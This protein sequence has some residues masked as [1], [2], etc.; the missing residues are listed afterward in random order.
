MIDLSTA[1][2][3]FSPVDLGALAYF[4]AAWVGYGLSVGRLRGRMVSLTQIMNRHRANWARQ[5]IGRDNRVVDTQI[6]ASLQNG[7][8]FFASTS[9]IALGSVLTLSRSGDDV[10]NMFA[11][12]PFGTVANR[13]TWELKVAGLA[14]VFV[15][16]F[17]KFAWA[18]RL[19]NYAAILLGAVP[20]RGTASEAEM[21]RAVRRV[22]VM[23]VAAGG[24]FARGQRAFFFALAYLGWFV[25]PYILFVSTTG[26]VAVMW[27]RQFASGIRTALLGLG[28]GPDEGP[29]AAI[30]EDGE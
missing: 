24:H 28:E 7:T 11:T 2:A 30:E 29:L 23:N 1:G 15:Y 22:A 17:F 6:N 3:A 13:V 14:V 18:Y 9:L 12:L 21:T 25:S 5:V 16:A 20:S 27:R 10:L 19:F 8:A 26:V 4:I